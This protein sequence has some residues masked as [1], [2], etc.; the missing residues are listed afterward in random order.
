M[1]ITRSFVPSFVKCIKKLRLNRDEDGSRVRYMLH[2]EKCDEPSVWCCCY[3]ICTA[4]WY[5]QYQS[6]QLCAKKRDQ[7]QTSPMTNEIDSDGLQG[8]PL[9][10]LKNCLRKMQSSLCLISFGCA[11]C[12]PYTPHTFTWDVSSLLFDPFVSS[13]FNASQIIPEYLVD[14]VLS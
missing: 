2:P 3:C 9:W 8:A 4:R 7:H 10:L 11:V 5:E 14:S 13:L 1:C 6:I 12:S